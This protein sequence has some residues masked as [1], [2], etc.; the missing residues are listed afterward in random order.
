MSRS[1]FR[2]L[3]VLALCLLLIAVY[4]NFFAA[5]PVASMPQSPKPAQLA[6]SSTDAPTEH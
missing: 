4:L 6:Q 3:N 5:P 1:L 2:I